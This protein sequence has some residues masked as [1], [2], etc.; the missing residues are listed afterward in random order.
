VTIAATISGFRPSKDGFAF[1]NRFSSAP[2]IRI[3][4]GPLGVLGIGDVAD[5]LCGGMCLL[6]RDAF[7]TGRPVAGP[8]LD[9]PSDGTP[10]SSDS[11]LMHRLVDAQ[12]ASLRSLR[13]PVRLYSLQAFRPER[14]DPVWSRLGRRTRT[15]ET[16]REWRRIR[17]T[18]DGGR[19]AFVGIV[20][21]TGPNPFDLVRHHQVLAFGYEVE[22]DRLRLQVYDP[23]HP[24][25]DDVELRLRLGIGG[26]GPAT[27][28]QTTGE[29]V[30]AFCLLA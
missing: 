1:A 2:A 6:V 13:A 5:G 19:L 29:P 23:N 10:P 12:V 30:E 25:R 22:G 24:G 18:I 9:A 11:P 3:P 17:R 7:A 27:M 26:R 16:V 15:V 21:V 28:L 20:R 14:H 4:L 8:P